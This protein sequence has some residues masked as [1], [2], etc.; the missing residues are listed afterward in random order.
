VYTRLRI[1]LGI[2]GILASLVLAGC[3][4]P[5]PSRPAVDVPE[6]S[7]LTTTSAAP[8]TTVTTTAATTTTTTTTTTA[9]AVQ[10]KPPTVTATKKPAPPPPKKPTPAKNC[11]PSY[12]TVCIAPAPP[13]LDCGDIPYRHFKVLPP[14]PHGFDADHDGEGC[15][16]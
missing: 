7:E 16:S 9:A 1:P 6:P 8:T 2:L 10:A 4:S 5:P 15:E 3:G 13:D 11:D 14:D 12:P